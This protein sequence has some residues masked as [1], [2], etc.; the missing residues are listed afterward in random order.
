MQLEHIPNQPI[1]F[2]DNSFSAQ[3]CINNDVRNYAQLMQ[4]DDVMCVQLKITC[5]TTPCEPESNQLL[6]NYELN[7]LDSWDEYYDII[8][9]PTYVSTPPTF[10]QS[11]ANEARSDIAAA[12][13][14]GITQSVSTGGFPILLAFD[15]TFYGGGTLPD[16]MFAGM[17]DLNGN[18]TAIILQDETNQYKNI[19][20]RCTLIVD[21][22]TISANNVFW[23]CYAGNDVGFK[24][25]NVVRFEDLCINIDSLNGSQ[26][27]MQN[28]F[29]GFY[30]MYVESVNGWQCKNDSQ[31]LLTNFQ[32][33]NGST[34]LLNFSVQNLD[35]GEHLIVECGGATITTI[36][37]NGNYSINYTHLVADDYVSFNPDK[38]GI[39]MVVS[40]LNICEICTT[41]QFAIFDR[42]GDR[43]SKWYS[44]G[45]P[46]WPVRYENDRLVWCVGLDGLKDL[47]GNRYSANCGLYRIGYQ[48]CADGNDVISTTV[49]SYNPD[50]IECTFL[51]EGISNGYAFGFY[52]GDINSPFFTLKQRL[53]ILHLNPL[54]RKKGEQYLYS[55]GS[56]KLTYAE[57]TKEREAWFDYV[58]ENTHDVIAVQLH[59]DQFT[60]NSIEYYADLED[61]E[62]EWNDAGK[63]NLAQSRVT[64][65]ST[66][67]PTLFNRSC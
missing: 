23:Q 4:D 57:S 8:G 32:L 50:P 25:L 46:D 1:L 59:C 18:Y 38:T 24:N 44:L 48:E 5:D 45:D 19:D 56:R 7:R 21:P 35:N 34:Y 12:N 39:D 15:Y 14:Y 30:W 65:I 37:E 51:V 31:S 42:F 67:N 43:D 52:F 40:S 2:E 16:N 10:W 41:T 49:I 47:D 33:L 62:P 22:N 36:T 61:Y 53:R 28:L 29:V 55:D 20:G 64:L 13:N 6:V 26:A 3:A 17:T 27:G 60:I 58:D 63:Y 9:F 11:P 54:Y 66:Q